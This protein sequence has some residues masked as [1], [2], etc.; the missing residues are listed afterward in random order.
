MK[1]SS[2]SV[3][4]DSLIRID[5][6]ETF[7]GAIFDFYRILTVI[8]SLTRAWAEEEARKAREHTWALEEARSQW[9]LQG[10]RV[11]VEGGLEDD[12]SPGV[13][14]ANVGKEHSVDE[15]INRAESL[16]EKLK[17]ISAEMKVRSC[18]AL[19]RVMQH[20]R[21]FIAILKQSA[22]NARQQ[23]SEFGFAAASKA[24][25]LA[26]EVQG[27]A[28]AFGLT[29]GDKSKRVV[30]DCKRVWISLLTDSRRIRGRISANTSI[31]VVQLDN[32]EY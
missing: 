21:S 12:A 14:W 11:V 32:G 6:Y 7:F 4:D 30:Q 15:T 17:S 24:N 31:G 16:L 5:L 13:T 19:D 1:D 25:K 29:I 10:I 20:L 8:P 3:Q 2:S 22:A 23:C 28:C 26:A 18:G 9:E 27:S